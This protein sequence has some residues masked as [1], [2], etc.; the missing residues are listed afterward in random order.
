MS[1]CCLSSFFLCY[2]IFPFD[3]NN[4]FKKKIIILLSNVNLYIEAFV[5][6]TSFFNLKVID[7]WMSS[8]QHNSILQHEASPMLFSLLTIIYALIA[9]VLV[10]LQKWVSQCHGVNTFSCWNCLA[11]RYEHTWNL[12]EFMTSYLDPKICLAPNSC[13]F[14]SNFTPLFSLLNRP[15][16]DS[17]HG[18]GRSPFILMGH[19]N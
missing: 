5:R 19:V 6:A 11:A 8:V 9:F 4:Y 12:D 17:W 16:V 3:L 2:S 14:P 1:R 7:I 13:C 18:Y 15:L 10:K